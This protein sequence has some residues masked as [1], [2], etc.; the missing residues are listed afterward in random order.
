MSEIVKY[1][2]DVVTIS[3]GNS[4]VP[5]DKEINIYS[6]ESTIDNK[7]SAMDT[8]VALLTKKC[9]GI[10]YGLIKDYKQLTSQ[11][12]QYDDAINQITKY[13][14]DKIVEDNNLQTINNLTSLIQH[15]HY[16][17]E[18]SVG[19]SHK[20]IDTLALPLFQIM[21][22]QEEAMLM[23]IDSW[24]QNANIN[25]STIDKYIRGEKLHNNTDIIPNMKFLTVKDQ[26]GSLLQYEQDKTDVASQSTVSSDENDNPRCEIKKLLKENKKEKKKGDM[27][28]PITTTHVKENK[29]K[30]KGEIEIK[31]D[32]Q[33]I[34]VEWEPIFMENGTLGIRNS[35]LKNSQ[36]PSAIQIEKNKNKHIGASNYKVL[37]T[38]ITNNRKGKIFPSESCMKEADQ[39]ICTSETSNYEENTCTE[40]SDTYFTEDF[41]D[42][43]TTMKSEVNNYDNEETDQVTDLFQVGDHGT[44]TTYIMNNEEE[45]IVEDSNS[46]LIDNIYSPVTDDDGDRSEEECYNPSDIILVTPNVTDTNIDTEVIIISKNK[47]DAIDIIMQS[48]SLL[49]KKNVI[50][51]SRSDVNDILQELNEGDCNSMQIVTRNIMKSD[52]ALLR[53]AMTLANENTDDD[54]VDTC[55]NQSDIEDITQESSQMNNYVND[56]TETSQEEANVYTKDV[57]KG[58]V[59]KTSKEVLAKDIK[60]VQKQTLDNEQEI[61]Y[62]QED[63][64]TYTYHEYN[65]V[66]INQLS[67]R[68]DG[69]INDCTSVVTGTSGEDHEI[70]SSDGEYPSESSDDEDSSS[71]DIYL[72]ASSDLEDQM[73]KMDDEFHPLPQN[74]FSHNQTHTKIIGSDLTGNLSE[75]NYEGSKICEG[76][77][78]DGRCNKCHLHV[79]S[80][81]CQTTI[82]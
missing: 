33:K 57:E 9:M 38:E 31:K 82:N 49:K 74:L 70:E 16:E 2:M 20:N 66:N 54:N 13:K 24:V 73:E 32:K 56:V 45:K 79:P 53:E 39:S 58:F 11:I 64:L 52:E 12:T 61:K 14:I 18:G 71:D 30:V 46:G 36:N 27:L 17:K 3:A 34:Q 68:N 59:A 19:K 69:K 28:Q 4:Q 44:W 26:V 15:A 42:N 6:N 65:L 7:S 5:E 35:S 8:Q 48:T 80:S 47:K 75:K 77:C 41:T 23:E 81:G 78:K 37:T 40:I 60:S 67:T 21:N 10:M 50:F 1:D 55:S 76:T 25:I 51:M 29:E 62:L 22:Y 63:L 43:Q 72:T